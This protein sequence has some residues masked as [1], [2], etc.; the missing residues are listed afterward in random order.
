[1]A[2]NPFA[3]LTPAQ[4][5]ALKAAGDYFGAK[6]YKGKL[7]RDTSTKRIVDYKKAEAK[8]LVASSKLAESIKNRTPAQSG[9]GTKTPPIV[10]PVRGPGNPGRPVA[11]ASKKGGKGSS[12]GKGNTSY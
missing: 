9:N 12:R 7:Q 8:R 3:N 4:A 1:M 11:P 2:T 6:G 10:R 5:K